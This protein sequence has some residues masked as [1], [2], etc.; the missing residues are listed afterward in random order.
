MLTKGESCHILFFTSKSV[1]IN[2]AL[3]QEGI[4][5]IS[6]HLWTRHGEASRALWVGKAEKPG[7]AKERDAIQSL[8]AALAHGDDSVYATRLS[9][10]RE[11]AASSSVLPLWF[12]KGRVKPCA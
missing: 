11:N 12:I 1:Y 2:A 10:L 9:R 7:Q 8:P 6:A 5:D 3:L 4:K